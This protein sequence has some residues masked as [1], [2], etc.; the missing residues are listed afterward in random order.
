M[1][2]FASQSH[3]S[4]HTPTLSSHLF[5]WNSRCSGQE[6]PSS[7]LMVHSDLDSDKTARA[8]SVQKL[9]SQILTL[10][11]NFSTLSFLL[12]LHRKKSSIES[13]LT[14]WSNLLDVNIRIIL[15]QHNTTAP[16]R[17]CWSSELGFGQICFK[18]WAASHKADPMAPTNPFEANLA[19]T[20]RRTCTRQESAAGDAN[21]YQANLYLI[22]YLVV[23]LSM[24]HPKVWRWLECLYYRLAI[25]YRVMWITNGQKRGTPNQALVSDEF[26]Q[27]CIQDVT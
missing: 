27:T 2:C 5:P 18:F 16:V 24:A 8:K 4:T 15:L 11:F 17:T 9:C 12:V 10:P 20:L 21:L 22:T 3:F 1:I 26:I 23:Q 6:H 7:N 19:T 14:T 25:E 13:S